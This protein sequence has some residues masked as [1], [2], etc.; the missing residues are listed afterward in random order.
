MVVLCLPT[1]WRCGCSAAIDH[2]SFD[3]S[4]GAPHWYLEIEVTMDVRL[5]GVPVRGSQLRLLLFANTRVLSL[6]F[7]RRYGYYYGEK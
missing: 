1:F 5:V 4:L 2:S 6:F 3:T 7:Y